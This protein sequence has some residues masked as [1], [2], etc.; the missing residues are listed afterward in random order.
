MLHE[1]LRSCLCSIQVSADKAENKLLDYSRIPSI[2]SFERLS[3][4]N[5]ARSLVIQQY[6]SSYFSVQANLLAIF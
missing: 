5:L 4:L 3:S 1:S 2:I 6:R